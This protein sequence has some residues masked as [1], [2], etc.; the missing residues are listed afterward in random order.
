[1]E[2]KTPLERLEDTIEDLT[3]NAEAVTEAPALN[4]VPELPHGLEVLSEEKPKKKAKKKTAKKALVQKEQLLEAP[5][6]FGVFSG[7]NRLLHTRDG[8]VAKF[9]NRKAAIV[10]AKRIGGKVF[11][12]GDAFV[13]VG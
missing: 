7:G 3:L 11:A 2:D 6:F 9:G 10:S 1:M 4:E 5:I 12:D 8:K 13:I